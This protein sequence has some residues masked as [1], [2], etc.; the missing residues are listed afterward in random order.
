M[1]ASDTQIRILS[2]R[3]GLIKLTAKIPGNDLRLHDIG[4]PKQRAAAQRAWGVRVVEQLRRAFGTARREFVFLAGELYADTITQ[5][6]RPLDAR[7]SLPGAAP[8]RGD[9]RP[10]QA[11]PHAAPG[12][13]DH[14]PEPEGGPRMR[15]CFVQRTDVAA[16]AEDG[17]R[18]GPQA[19][20]ASARDEHE[21]G[22]TRVQRFR[23]HA[24]EVAMS[25]ITKTKHAPTKNVLT[26]V[27][28]IN[29][30]PKSGNAHRDRD[31][32]PC[33]ARRDRRRGDTRGHG[34]A[35]AGERPP[36]L[37]Q[38]GSALG[39]AHVGVPSRKLVQAGAA[40]GDARVGVPP[41]KPCT[42]L[43][44]RQ[45][46]PPPPRVGGLL[47][48]GEEFRVYEDGQKAKAVSRNGQG[49]VVWTGR[50]SGPYEYAT[51]TS[52]GLSDEQCAELLRGINAG[53]V[54]EQMPAG[55]GTAAEPDAPGRLQGDA[56]DRREVRLQRD[57]RGPP[58][59]PRPRRG[60]RP[61]RRTG[62]RRRRRRRRGVG[63]SR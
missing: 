20:R 32:S 11:R 57:A 2:G 29:L 25:T 28:T 4:K 22:E 31:R 39:D 26:V 35:A 44:G 63:S 24:P 7:W 42:R 13:R 16:A 46:C 52:P 54:A 23:R 41:R 47:L 58:R 38:A 9:R 5:A 60:R 19:G 8:P 48:N 37:A 17:R 1:V 3:H 55:G 21:A 53:H 43:G 62:A 56:G 45:L 49:D 61:G 34:E 10:R 51:L 18:R 27:N 30:D 14:P 59:A 6:P 33:R 50:V 15:L 12:A 36:P 40:L